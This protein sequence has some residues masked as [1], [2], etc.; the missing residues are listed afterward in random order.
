MT[1]NISDL[2]N[3]THSNKKNKRKSN[4]PMNPDRRRK[5]VTVTGPYIVYM[6][7]DVDIIEDWTTIKKVGHLQL[8]M[9]VYSTCFV[10]KEVFRFW[11]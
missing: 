10:K 5:P 1:F 2:W 8:T 3:E 7:K 4:D 6:L 9:T 11:N